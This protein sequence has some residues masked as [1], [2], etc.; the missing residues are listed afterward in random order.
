VAAEPHEPDPS[1]LL[2]PGRIARH[3]RAAPDR[4]A[5]VAGD[6]V[7]TYGALDAEADRLAHRLAEAGGKG[8]RVAH[9]LADG[10]AVFVALLA[11][12]KTGRINH[13]LNHRDP[14]PRLRAL[15]A[16]SAP[17]AIVTAG[18]L[19]G[20][21]A[22]LAGAG[23]RVIRVDEDA[24]GAAPA[25]PDVAL[26]PADGAYLVYTSGS[27]GAP[28]AVLH[29]QGDLARAALA[30]GEMM[31]LG[32]D[33]RVALLS[34]LWGAQAVGT[35]W[36]TLASGGTLLPFPVV[37]YGT[38]GLGAWL[39]E[40]RI[41]AYLSAASLFRRFMATL[42]PEAAFPLVRVVKASSDPATWDDF[43]LLRRHFPNAA[44]L[45]AMGSSEV[46]TMLGVL[47]G[48]ETEAG[49]GPLPVGRACPGLAFRIVDADGRDVPAGAVGT[50]RVRSPRLFATYWRD[51]GLSAR[52]YAML[53]DGT[54][55]FRSE[56]LVRL[57]SDGNVVHAGRGDAVY[58]IRGQRVDIAE[59]ETLL[60]ALPGV[61]DGAAVVTDGPEGE[62]RLV[63]FVVPRAGAPPGGRKIRDL[64]RAAMPRHMVPSAFGALPRLPRTANGKVDRARL[65]EM[66]PPMPKGGTGAAE[67]ETERQL[68]ASW[69]EAFALEG[70][71]R[72]DD[73]F[74]LGGDSLIA[75]TIAT[76][77][78]AALGVMLPFEA[79]AGTPVLKDMAAAIDAGAWPARDEPL[80]PMPR[81]GDIPV[82]LLQEPF[83]RVSRA[84][85]HAWRYTRASEIRLDGPL[86]RD[87]LRFALDAVVARHELL[88]TRYR[89]EGEA[90]FQVV[91]P[92]APVPLPFIDL[93]DLPAPEEEARRRLRAEATRSLDLVGAPPIGFQLL[94]L[95]PDAHILLRTSHHI[96]DDAPS[97][98]IFLRDLGELY[99]ARIEER[100]PAL[101]AL[102][103]QYADY[104]IWQRRVWR[105]DGPRFREAVRWLGDRLA[106]EPAPPVLR[107]LPGYLRRRPLDEDSPRH[108]LFWGFDEATADGLARLAR[109]ETATFYAVRLAILAPVIA[110]ITG[111]EAV[112]IGGVFTNRTG[113]G[114]E[115]MFGPLANLVPLVVRCDRGAS[116]REHLR[117]VRD[118][119]T[120]AHRFAGLPL[121]EVAKALRENG[122]EAP[123]P[124][125][126]IHVPTQ[127]PPVV[128][129][130]LRMSQRGARYVGASGVVMVRFDPLDELHGASVAIDP[131]LYAPE[132]LDDLAA[133]LRDFGSAAARDPDAP[134]SRI[135]PRPG[136]Q[137][138][139]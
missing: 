4:P 13:V 40:S 85:S 133:R 125:L 101:P 111:H 89:P 104:A 102:P 31:S 90:V 78:D 38:A 114:V 43:R 126:W 66:A 75:A 71:G 67:T 97:W 116:F 35:T 80:R 74:D 132:L 14:E 16:D 47:L 94:R 29:A 120:E 36:A 53:P 86:D 68:A 130:G 118:G 127:T 18:P 48:P 129:G 124:F 52:R 110:A 76:R 128:A 54:R 26:A 46:G 5:I 109:A 30:L 131:R 134:L 79:F 136:P 2:V 95:G 88:R 73:F 82:S 17:E 56:D 10:P 83:W 51:P 77:L 21:A 135:A 34:A 6:A 108:R 92:A 123:A 50:L 84:P 58:K 93:A 37:D 20:L 42:A 55:E 59:V 64:A 49:R 62:P 117:R 39:H 8:D 65:R 98:N 19:A 27:T 44:M 137:S 91:E 25:P 22:R 3:A 99:A 121:A 96:L 72:N 112:T 11:T 106:A 81:D 100:P 12:L 45:S 63:G 103:V 33:D 24:S 87:A 105:R 113:A 32:P 7:L 115:S 70:V 60:A 139:A 23:T 41:T 119:V 9:L 138:G 107:T 15:L 1:G 122:I 69:A 61:E 57:G 28:K